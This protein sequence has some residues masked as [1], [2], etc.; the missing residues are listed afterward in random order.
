MNLNKKEVHNKWERRRG[1]GERKTEEQEG[2]LSMLV[3]VCG[4]PYIAVWQQR[5]GRQREVRSNLSQ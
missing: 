4:N 1:G 5:S 2:E 3:H